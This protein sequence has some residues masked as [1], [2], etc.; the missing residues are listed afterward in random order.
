MISIIV[1]VYNTGKYLEDCMESLIGQTY[2]DFEIV[3]IDDGSTDGS[4][5]VCD[6]WAKKDHRVRVYHQENQGLA[7]VRNKGLELA[8]GEYIAWVDG[9]DYVDKC[10]LEK[11]LEGQKCTGADMVMC[12]FYTDTDGEVEHT[13][14]ELFRGE[15]LDRQTFLE[16]LY[17]YGMYSVVWNKLLSKEAY[18][19][20]QF[21]TGRV[22]EDSSVMRR[23]TNNCNKVVVIEEPLY[24][25]RRHKESITLQQRTEAKSLKYV[26][27]TY[28]WLKEEVEIFQGE[29]N[30]KLA[31][32]ASR[33]LCDAILR[34]SEGLQKKNQVK[35]KR[36]YKV[37]EKEILR[38][39]GFLLRT[40][41]KYFVG[42]FNFSLCRRLMKL[43]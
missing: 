34:Y 41:V 24:F 27:D 13:G 17:T 43:I 16:R 12:S 3:V 11:L 19:G 36:I 22:F 32:F 28:L 25:Y 40:K 42:G 7:A 33:H 31:A 6:Q 20:I 5:A 26:N 8:G 4:A 9:D 14:R 23:L 21:P 39:K 29:R 18:Q 2:G 38:Y 15:E 37:Y 10:Y 35:W 30:A 1:P